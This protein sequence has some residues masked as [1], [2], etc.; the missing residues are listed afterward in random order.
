[1]RGAIAVAAI[2][3]ACGGSTPGQ[4]AS[5]VTPARP[6]TPPA[7]TAGDTAPGIIPPGLGSL[8]QDDIAIRLTQLG[9]AVRATPLDESVIR[10]LSPDSYRAL[11]ELAASKHEEVA[12][13]AR[14]TG[15]RALSSWYV[16]FFNT[17]QGEARF[18]PTSLTINNVGR[19]FRP[20]EIIPLTPGFGSQRLAQRESQSAIVLFDEA[21][22]ANQPLT[23]TYESVSNSG[24]SATLQRIER[25]RALIRARAR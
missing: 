13:I 24:W 11:S 15:Q 3:A 10:T 17:E 23:L 25:E 21:L 20:I 7:T 8:R 2:A 16:T 18:T 4:G 22:D 9:L 12:R 14:R 6:P 19:D 1:M 5:A